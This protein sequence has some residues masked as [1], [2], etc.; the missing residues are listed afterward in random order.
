MSTNPLNSDIDTI[1]DLTAHEV[2]DL[3][4][5]IGQQKEYRNVPSYVSDELCW[6][7]SSLPLVLELLPP[8]SLPVLQLLGFPTPRITGLTRSTAPDAFFSFSEA[9]HLSLECCHIPAPTSGFL[10]QLQASA[11]QAMLDGKVSIQH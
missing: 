1:E 9:T 6:R 7:T 4:L 11:G 5:W 2:G 3:S 8:D 10:R